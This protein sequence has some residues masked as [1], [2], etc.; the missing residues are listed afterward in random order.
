[1]PVD[2][3]PA[4]NLLICAIIR[5]HALIFSVATLVI[6]DVEET[7]RP[8]AALNYSIVSHQEAVWLTGLPRADWGLQ[9]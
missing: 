7:S 6:I 1:M 2:S 9:V 8:S 5:C 3:G 4:F